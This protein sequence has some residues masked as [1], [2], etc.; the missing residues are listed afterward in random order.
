MEGFF[1][2][3]L[4]MINWYAYSLVF[5]LNKWELHALVIHSA[6]IHCC[7]NDSGV[8]LWLNLG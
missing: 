8:T 6:L 4:K 7:S 5:T 1:V 3:C 2:F